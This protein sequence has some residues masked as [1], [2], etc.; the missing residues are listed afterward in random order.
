MYVRRESPTLTC[1]PS[2]GHYSSQDVSHRTG[3]EISALDVSPDKTLA[4]LAGREILKTVRIAGTRCVEETTS[5]RPSSTM[6]R[7]TH[8][9]PG[10][11]PSGETTSA[12]TT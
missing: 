3:L 8:R 10:L 12:S 5:A 6:P 9:A 7:T 2:I 1:P 4:L 11:R